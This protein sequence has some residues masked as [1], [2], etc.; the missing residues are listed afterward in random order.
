MNNGA[1]IKRTR[2]QELQDYCKRF[3]LYVARYSPRDGVSRYRFFLEDTDY[4]SGN[5]K[6][7]ALGLKEAWTYARGFAE[8]YYTCIEDNK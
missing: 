3:K 7:T 2:L 4:F 5:G 8:G 6:Y 1:I